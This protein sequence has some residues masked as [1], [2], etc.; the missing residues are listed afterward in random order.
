MKYENALID[1]KWN[2]KIDEKGFTKMIL[3]YLKSTMATLYQFT[4][5]SKIRVVTLSFYY[6]ILVLNYSWE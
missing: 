5:V 2:V 4:H 1:T 6:F 3:I